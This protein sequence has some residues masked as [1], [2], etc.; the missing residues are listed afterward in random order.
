MPCSK[1]GRQCNLCTVL[2]TST[3]LANCKEEGTFWPSLAHLAPYLGAWPWRCRRAAAWPLS[4]RIRSGEE[5]RH[6]HRLQPKNR[7]GVR[8]GPGRLAMLGRCSSRSSMSTP[9][10]GDMAPLSQSTFAREP[11]V[12]RET[13]ARCR[14]AE[15]APGVESAAP[16]APPGV[17]PGVRMPAGTGVSAAAVLLGPRR[18]RA[19]CMRK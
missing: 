11:G 8:G 5:A 19:R 13:A 14:C 17:R 3:F 6:A 18:E 2:L 15:L 12:C 4:H 16:P 1:W 9:E 7:P 10:A